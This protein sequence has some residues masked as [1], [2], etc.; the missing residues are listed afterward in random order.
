MYHIIVYELIIFYEY[1]NYKKENI[2]FYKD[3]D[4][5]NVGIGTNKRLIKH[6]YFKTIYTIDNVSIDEIS[7]KITALKKIYKDSKYMIE[8][9]K[10]INKSYIQKLNKK[11]EKKYNDY[12]MNRL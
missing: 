3:I 4:N 6:K 11:S 10:D 8:F 5:F 2:K 7:G 9:E 1:Q 12:M